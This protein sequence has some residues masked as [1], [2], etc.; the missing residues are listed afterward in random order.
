MAEEALQ[1]LEW[2][3]QDGVKSTVRIDG[4]KERI[5]VVT[6]TPTGEPNKFATAS[7]NMSFETAMKT[8]QN[9]SKLLGMA[10]YHGGK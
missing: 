4:A 6:E 2:T 9:I 5:Y 8:M 10:G 3:G 7:V 1:E